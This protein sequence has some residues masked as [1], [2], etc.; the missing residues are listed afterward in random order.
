MRSAQAMMWG[1][2]LSLL[3]AGAAFSAPAESRFRS[4]PEERAALAEQ[5]RERRYSE[6]TNAVAWA[7]SRG[8]PV[9]EVRD[10]RVRELMEVRDGKPIYY[11]TYNKNAAISTA[12]DLVRDDAAFGVDG[13][14]V[15]VGVWDGGAVL[16]NH[17]ELVGRVTAVDDVNAEN[18]ATHVAGTIGASGVNANA[19]GMA[20]AVSIRS[21]EWNNDVVEL[22]LAGADGPGQSDS[23]YLSNHSYGYEIADSSDYFLFGLYSDHVRD[24]DQALHAMEYCLPFIASGNER[25]NSPDG[26]DTVSMFGVAKNT[27]TV[28]SVN[29]AVSS[30][31]RSLSRATI[32]S[33]SSFGPA[34]DGRIKPDIVAN[35][36]AVYSSG[37]AG[38][39]YYYSA[40]GTSMASP[41]AC[42]SVA[43][44]VEFYRNRTNGGAMRASTLKGL[45]IHT[46]DDLGRPGPDYQYGWGLM[47]TLEAAALIRDVTE[48]HPERMID[49][50]LIDSVTTSQSYTV[51]SSGMAPLRVTL[52]WNDEPGLS[53]GVSDNERNP[54]LVNDL[55]LKIIGP[56]GQTNY[57]Y[58]L[59][60]A[61]PTANAVTTGENSLDN[62]EQVLI[63][64]PA[65]GDYTIV[66]DCDEALRYYSERRFSASLKKGGTQRYSLLISGGTGD[67]DGDSLPDDW[68]LAFFGGETNAVASAD[69]DGDGVDN[70]SEYIAGTDPTDSADR[71][72]VSEG[73]PATDAGFALS[74]EP[75][76][77][78][79]YQVDWTTNLALPFVPIADGLTYPVGTYTDSVHRAGTEHFYRIGVEFE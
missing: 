69:A 22:T 3:T 52:C 16:T 10:G 2:L 1:C 20:P 79:S 74:W 24:M 25:I 63:D 75:L 9:R 38:Q 21:Y 61:A 76:P 68:E 48:A 40:N 64:L 77:G 34:D 28:G 29:D 19:K 23:I 30:G 66:V 70:L 71:F 54:D 15:I 4:H 13:S 5:I 55:D 57:P 12:A 72:S 42:G 45:I 50:E 53:D 60:Y 44:L 32:S 59:S 8:I 31:I 35:G 33:F 43:L 46:A 36:Y 62:V 47:N 51:S 7:Q 11:T 78:R 56:D 41:N 18:H 17:V 58:S 67:V 49:A 73:S 37:S 26:Y 14:G 39:T 6:K 65:P 27:I